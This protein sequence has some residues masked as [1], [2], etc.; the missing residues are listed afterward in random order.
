[1][2]PRDIVRVFSSARKPPRGV[3]G[4]LSFPPSTLSAGCRTRFVTSACCRAG[5]STWQN[6]S[7]YSPYSHSL[8]QGFCS[9]ALETPFSSQESSLALRL[10]TRGPAQRQIQPA[11]TAVLARY[12]PTSQRAAYA[13]QPWARA[14]RDLPPMRTRDSLPPNMA[15]GAS[16]ENI[17]HRAFTL[18]HGGR[19]SPHTARRAA[20]APQRRPRWDPA[21]EK[22]ATSR[23]RSHRGRN[24]KTP[25]AR[26][27]LAHD[28]Q[29]DLR[30][31][32]V[33][34]APGGR[35]HLHVR[36]RRRH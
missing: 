32:R 5:A 2:T 17:F 3:L 35:R 33:A 36:G 8:Q 14:V 23:H 13:L 18:E 9:A 4:R 22:R 19:R 20:V 11:K 34:R 16:A 24:N 29:Q 7:H 10:R 15:V 26:R 30:R 27:R 25:L 21:P 31:E 12:Q 28:Q 1:M 6:S